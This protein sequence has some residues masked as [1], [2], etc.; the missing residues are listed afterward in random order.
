MSDEFL[1][2]T[3]VAQ[4]YFTG[5]LYCELILLWMEFQNQS[6]WLHK[7]FVSTIKQARRWC[8]SSTHGWQYLTHMRQWKLMFAYRSCLHNT[9]RYCSVIIPLM[10]SFLI[11]YIDFRCEE[12]PFLHDLN[13]LLLKA[14]LWRCLGKPSSSLLAELSDIALNGNFSG[15]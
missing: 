6:L 3:C 9:S 10:Q 4:G 11:N 1:L 15:E 12:R 8:F 2:N 5:R 14:S 7:K 13:L